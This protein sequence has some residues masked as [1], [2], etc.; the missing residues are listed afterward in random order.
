MQFNLSHLTVNQVRIYSN[1]LFI[2]TL[3]LL[4]LVSTALRADPKTETRSLSHDQL[5]MD[6]QKDAQDQ[7]KAPSIITLS[8]AEY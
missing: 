6:I 4:V 5:S 1:L 7:E 8:V 3:I 2:L